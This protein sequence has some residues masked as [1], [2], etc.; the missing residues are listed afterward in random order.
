MI[1]IMF[2]R[3]GLLALTL[4]AAIALNNIA[5]IVIYSILGVL[6]LWFVAACLAT[7]G[8]AVG[9][10]RVLGTLIVCQTTPASV[11]GL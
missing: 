5:A 1:Y 11:S 7:I 9:E 8:D 2:I 10:R 4:V 3:T 6:G